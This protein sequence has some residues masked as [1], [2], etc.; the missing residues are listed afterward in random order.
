MT[1]ILSEIHYITKASHNSWDARYLHDD[2]TIF[3]KFVEEV[4][5]GVGVNNKKMLFQ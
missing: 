5:S 1:T 2:Q 3:Q 4:N